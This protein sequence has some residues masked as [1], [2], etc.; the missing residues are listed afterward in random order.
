MK[1]ADSNPYT[2]KTRRIKGE[3]DMQDTL[4]SKLELFNSFSQPV[5]LVREGKV[6]YANH[7]AAACGIDAAQDAG[8]FVEEADEGLR[9]RLGSICARAQRHELS[10]AVLYIADEYWEGAR[11]SPDTLLNVAQA[12]R[13]PLTD[14][15]TVSAPLFVTLEEMEDPALSR[16]AA[17]LNKSFYQLLRLMC[18]L[19]E[20]PAVTEGNVKVRLE[21]LELCAFLQ[22]I[23]TQAESLC[24]TCRR[25]I[26]LHLPDK[27]VHIWADRDR[28]A[29]AI[30]NLIAS[31]VRH[32]QEGAEIT[33]S[34]L[35][36]ASVAVIEI[37]DPA[38]P[39]DR[40]RGTLDLP[41]TRSEMKTIDADT[42]FGFAI[43]RAIARS[44]GGTL[45]VGAGDEGGT[46]AAMSLSL[47]TPVET[48]LM[49]IGDEW[50]VLILRDRMDGTKRFGELKKSIGHVTQKVLTAQLR[51]MEAKGLLTR[52]VYA[53]VPP[54]VEYTLTPTGYSL[55]PILDSMVAWG[56]G[57]QQQMS[58]ADSAD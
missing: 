47:Q 1:P 52:R 9:L 17:S 46:T 6:V 21:K 40:L 16:A 8:E 53:E 13:T 56:T 19:T 49:L 58:G 38:A 32:T 45:I 50:K 10:D 24:R 12:M 55:R 37:H 4:E 29:R 43:A 25:T 30:Y 41:E 48:T 57:Y 54:R 31:A 27:T 14:M 2:I 11:F 20:M 39:G 23:F 36:A 34:L 33:L 26:A 28:L 3:P 44:H 15:F 5:I 51:D 42:G 7:A 22:S 18:D 35:T